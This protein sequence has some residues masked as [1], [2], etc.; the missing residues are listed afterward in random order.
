MAYHTCPQPHR[1]HLIQKLGFQSPVCDP[2]YLCS[3]LGFA[4]LRETQR[5]ASGLPEGAAKVMDIKGLCN[6]GTCK[7]SSDDVTR[8]PGLSETHF[9][10]F[11]R[12]LFLTCPLPA[13]TWHTPTPSK[14]QAKSYLLQGALPDP[15]GR[16]GPCRYLVSFCAPAHNKHT[17]NPTRTGSCFNHL[18]SPGPSTV[19]GTGQVLRKRDES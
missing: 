2:G 12:L 19:S 16:V 8:K 6:K 1:G 18:L 17:T 14:T 15:S 4:L 9:K 10:T 3:P 13:S 11:P 7:H 5:S